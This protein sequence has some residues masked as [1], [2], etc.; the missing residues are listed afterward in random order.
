MGNLLNMSDFMK[1]YISHVK[2]SRGQ[3]DGGRDTKICT[4]VLLNMLLCK[5]MVLASGDR[6]LG[7][8]SHIG[9]NLTE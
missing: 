5:E 4:P 6:A 2:P 1:Q 3:T 8:G 7:Q 9:D